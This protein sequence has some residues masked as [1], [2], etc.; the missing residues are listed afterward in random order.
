M[1]SGPRLHHEEVKVLSSPHV[2][3]FFVNP[4]EIME[5]QLGHSTKFPPPRRRTGAL[6]LISGAS[7]LFVD[8]VPN[9]ILM[10]GMPP[11]CCHLKKEPCLTHMIHTE[12][13]IFKSARTRTCTSTHTIACLQGSVSVTQPVIAKRRVCATI[14]VARCSG[15][16]RHAVLATSS[17]RLSVTP[18]NVCPHV[19]L[20]T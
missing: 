6:S 15:F 18:Q 7:Q 14:M 16:G 10:A 2:R 1:R 8:I 19:T 5:T 9:C 11:N 12:T 4:G 17:S 13:G 3:L 20:Y